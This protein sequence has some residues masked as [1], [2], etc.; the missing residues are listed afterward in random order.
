MKNRIKLQ[1]VVVIAGVLAIQ[2]FA[3]AE[4]AC[5]PSPC[6][7]GRKSSPSWLGTCPGRFLFVP[8]TC[9]TICSF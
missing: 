4:E 5:K 6:T 1:A 8:T 2:P 7:N 3:W 9:N